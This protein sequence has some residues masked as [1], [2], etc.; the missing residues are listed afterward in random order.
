MTQKNPND[1]RE[2]IVGGGGGGGGGG[3][4][5][6]KWKVSDLLITFFLFRIRSLASC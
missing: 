1:V 3:V 5:L 2:G 6:V 4:G